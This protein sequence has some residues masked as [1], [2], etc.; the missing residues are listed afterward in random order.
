MVTSKVAPINENLHEQEQG[1][2]SSQG[3]LACW[4]AS[5]NALQLVVRVCS[6]ELFLG[7][8][9]VDFLVVRRV[10]LLSSRRHQV[11]VLAVFLAPCGRV[12]SK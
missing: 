5:A 1:T 12:V 9:C 10:S 4:S 8:C 2:D 7:D 3:W 6:C 11:E